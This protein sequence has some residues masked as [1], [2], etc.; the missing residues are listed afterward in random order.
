M[1]SRSKRVQQQITMQRVTTVVQV[2]SIMQAEAEK[3]G[4]WQRFK[5]ANTFLWKKNIDAFFQLASSNK[6]AD[7]G[8]EVQD[9]G[10][11]S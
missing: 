10:K 5:L 6:E 3:M 1:S 11:E 2:L 7:N 8:R 4:W 9:S